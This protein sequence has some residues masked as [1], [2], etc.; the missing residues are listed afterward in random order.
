MGGESGENKSLPE[1]SQP[2][3][4]IFSGDT[5]SF[6]HHVPAVGISASVSAPRVAAADSSS[7]VLFRVFRGKL[8]STWISFIDP[9][10][11]LAASSGRLDLGKQSGNHTC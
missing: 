9:L 2:W 4:Q 6:T 11:L 7:T 3:L 8:R 5:L 10:P 1:H